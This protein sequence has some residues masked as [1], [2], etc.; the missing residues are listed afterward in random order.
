MGKNSTGGISLLAGIWLIISPFI[1]KFS[2]FGVSAT[3]DVIVGVIV[4]LMALIYLY[5]ERQ[6]WTA[7]ISLLAG[8]WL[9]ISPFVMSQSSIMPVVTNNIIL[10]VIV[11][12]LGIAAASMSS[13]SMES[14]RM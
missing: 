12:A 8:L 3:N 4:G 10:G 11:G 9:I 1:L 5:D 14:P 7:W 2:N 13:T 6:I